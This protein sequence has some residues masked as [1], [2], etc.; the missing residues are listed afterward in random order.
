MARAKQQPL[1]DVKPKEHKDVIAVA[2]R[3]VDKRDDRMALL[4]EEVELKDELI[5]VMEKHKL[6]E[7]VYDGLKITLVKSDKVSVKVKVQKDEDEDED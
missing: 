3:Y 1:M 4:K 2:E 5:K 6:E 7:Y